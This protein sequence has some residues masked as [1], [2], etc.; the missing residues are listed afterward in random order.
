MLPPPLRVIKVIHAASIGTNLSRCKGVLSVVSIED[1]KCFTRPRK[2]LR[3]SRG[4]IEFGDEDLEGRTQLHDDALVVTT[5]IS[6]FVVKRV[7]VDQ[8]SGVEMMHPNLY[9]RLG[10]KRENLSKYNTLLVWFDGRMVIL[11]GQISLL[12]NIEGKE[13]MVNFIM[14]NSF[15][16]Y[17][18]CTIYLACKGEVSHQTG[19]CRGK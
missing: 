7:L 13:V 2:K 12:V 19:D 6:G 15:S 3:L 9:K 10:L 11:E 14:V 17:G 8:E 5:R 16:P 1:S 4:S 18:S